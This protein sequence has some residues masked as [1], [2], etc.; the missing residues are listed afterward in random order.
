MAPNLNVAQSVYITGCHVLAIWGIYM[1]CPPD[2]YQL[3]HFGLV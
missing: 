1:V 3:T 2:R